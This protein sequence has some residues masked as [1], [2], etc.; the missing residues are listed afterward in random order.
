M[1]STDDFDREVKA[2]VTRGKLSSSAVQTVTDLAMTNI[3]A[4]AQLVSTLYRHHRKAAAPNKLVSLYLIDA[5]AREAKTRQKKAERESQGKGKAPAPGSTTPTDSPPDVG[6]EAAGGGAGDFAGFLQKLEAVLSKIVLDNWENGLPDHREKVRKVLD[7]WTR[8]STFSATALAR[9]ETKLLATSSSAPV[10]QMSPGRPSLSPGPAAVTPPID[11]TS[12]ST[13]GAIPANVLALLQAKSTPSQAALEQKKHDDVE[14]EVERALRE[15]REGIPAPGATSGPAPSSSAPYN[16]TQSQSPYGSS[17]PSYPSAPAPAR[18][19]YAHQS[20]SAS[21][22]PSAEPSSYHSG[23][24]GPSSA[25]PGPPHPFGSSASPFPGSPSQTS[26]GQYPSSS[27]APP[28]RGPPGGFPPHQRQDSGGGGGGWRGDSAQ[29]PYPGY[30]DR[31]GRSPNQA[32]ASYRSGSGGGPPRGQVRPFEAMQ[33]SAPAASRDEPPLKRP[34]QPGSA[35]PYSGPSGT[36]ES[37][38]ASTAGAPTPPTPAAQAP[39]PAPSAALNTAAPSFDPST[40]DATS[41]ASWAAFV[42]VL[43]GAH[44]YFGSLGRV[45]TMEEVMNFCVPSA[46]MA[47][48]SAGNPGGGAGGGAGM[49]MGMGGGMGTGMGMGMG[50]PPMAGGFGAG[51]GFPGPGMAPPPVSSGMGPMQPRG[52]G[53]GSPYP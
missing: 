26:Q 30:G 35:A 9:I 8:A 12:S 52:M 34:F 11:S 43:R 51:G 46:M 18:P 50:G 53:Q 33:Q 31:D 17:T 6:P 2:L 16:A 27:S 41:P 21:S 47:F 25:R 4:D 3:R 28:P 10:A 1:A 23:G 15:A 36:G 29:T 13:G 40:F 19:G 5:V 49:G 44:P 22:M 48:G 39:Q 38:M 42:D 20:S 7:I 37:G 14:S 45:P 24:G 32:N